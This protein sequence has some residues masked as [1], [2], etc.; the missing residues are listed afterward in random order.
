MNVTES[1]LGPRTK[2]LSPYTQLKGDVGKL[3]YNLF[4]E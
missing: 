2:F 3:Y 4:R 1:D